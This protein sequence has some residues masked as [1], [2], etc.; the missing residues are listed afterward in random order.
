[1]QDEGTRRPRKARPLRLWQVAAIRAAWRDQST[2]NKQLAIR[3]GV[4]RAC[5]SRVCNMSRHA[6]EEPMESHAPETITVFGHPA[7]Q[8]SKRAVGTRGG[9]AIMVESS[10]HLKPWR[11]AVTAAAVEAKAAFRLRPVML[12]IIVRWPR[13]ASHL[14]KSGALRSGAPMF[15][16]MVDADKLARG[17]LDALT[18]CAYRD[19]RQVVDLHIRREWCADGTPSHAEIRISDAA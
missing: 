1:M 14:T 15:P 7:G 18:G 8:G 13:P 16:S 5:I 3:Y 10:R 17:I 2:M 19:D 11:Q 6:Q 12:D 9:R 4:S